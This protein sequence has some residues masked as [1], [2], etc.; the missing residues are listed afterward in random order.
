MYYTAHFGLTDTPFSITPDPHY[1]YLS[2]CHDEALAHLLY[3]VNEGSGFVLLTGEVGTGKTTLCRTLMEKLPETVDVALLLNPRLSSIELLIAMFDELRISHDSQKNNHTFKYFTD[4][5]TSYLLTAHAVGRRTVL[6]LDEAQNLS[7]EVLEQLRLLTNLETTNQKLL[8]IVLV[9]QPELNK[10]LARN[11]LRQLSQRITARY[12]LSPLSFQE[13]RAYIKH[14]LSV[15]GSQHSL[16][17]FSAKYL[18]YRYSKGIPRVINILCE[19]SL[20]GGFTQKKTQ[21]NYKIV[22][23]AE[24]EINGKSIKLPWIIGI[25]S[26]ILLVSLFIGTWFFMTV[27]STPLTHPLTQPSQ[28]YTIPSAHTATDFLHFLKT[29]PENS[30]VLTLFELWKLKKAPLTHQNMCKQ[31]TRQGVACLVS[32]GTWADLH[33]L[34]RP[35]VITLTMGDVVVTALQDDRVTLKILNKEF[36]FLQ[37]DLNKYWTGAFMLLWSP[38]SLPLKT[39]KIGKTDHAVLWIRKHLPYSKNRLSLH[40]DLDLKEHVIA[41]QRAQNLKP[42][43][44]V[45]EQTMLVLQAF[46]D[47]YPLLH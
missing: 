42:D 10:K 36:S 40:F 19:R 46:S 14:R 31:A 24:S 4:I 38:P 32:S 8:Q 3:G 9:G 17:T 37:R 28:P 12:N 43:G 47:K 6:I 2:T 23:F 1:L 22:L 21:I 29:S 11:Q 35:A 30:A 13:T 20:L 15:S 45:G 26:S 44:I 33:R 41:F 27:T 34:N 39:M 16:F 25:V 5:L 18:V 7:I